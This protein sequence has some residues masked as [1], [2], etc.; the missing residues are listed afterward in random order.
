MRQPQP[1][2]EGIAR[3]LTESQHREVGEE[4]ACRSAELRPRGN[5]PALAVMARP[6]HREENRAAP[7]AAHADALERA[8]D[9]EDHRAPHANPIVARQERH[10]ER[11]NTHQ[12]QGGDERGLAADAI[13]IMTEDEGADRACD[14]ADEINAKRVER[15]GHWVLVWEE[16]FTEDEPGHGA[17]EKEIV[18]LDRGADRCGDDG[19]AELAIVLVRRK[20]SI[21]VGERSHWSLLPESI[22]VRLLRKNFTFRLACQAD[23]VPPAFGGHDGVAMARIVASRQTLVECHNRQRDRPDETR[24]DRT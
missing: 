11:R 5:E 4:E 19:P 10:Q 17:V 15:R 12:H 3:H 20:R 6:L 21:D 24:P 22:Y 14:E 7:L 1:G 9:G 13:A 2:Q 23:R 8:Q 16:E 18:P